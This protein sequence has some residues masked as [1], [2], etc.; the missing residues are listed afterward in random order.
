MISEAETGKYVAEYF[1]KML[2][3]VFE[4]GDKSAL[5]YAIYACL[6]LRRPMPEWLRVAFLDA[7]E[8]A[9]RFEIRSW[10]EVFDRPV[11][12]GMHLKTKRRNAQLRWAIIERVETLKAKKR[13]DKGL[14]EKVARDLKIKGVK[15]T[16]VS[17]IY[18]DKRN[19]ELRKCFR[20]LLKNPGI[21]DSAP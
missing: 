3:R 9:E 16:T 20:D 1:E 12:K 18:Y 14:F 15:G 11:A 6:E 17:E 21:T 2:K 5:L 7:Y 4:A 13:V 8:A 19:R 10:D